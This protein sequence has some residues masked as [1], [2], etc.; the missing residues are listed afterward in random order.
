VADLALALAADFEQ[1]GFLAALFALGSNWTNY[2]NTPLNF[3]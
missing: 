2:T 3:G 1:V